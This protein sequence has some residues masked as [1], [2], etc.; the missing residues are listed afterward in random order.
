MTGLHVMGT[1]FETHRARAELAWSTCSPQVAAPMS[2]IV[3][4][5]AAQKRPGGPI[6]VTS[7]LVLLDSAI[8]MK[9]LIIR[10]VA[11]VMTRAMTA[12]QCRC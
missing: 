5:L 3:V 8:N 10:I 2:F 12:V 4:T 6:Y 7:V 11:S 1:P 9:L